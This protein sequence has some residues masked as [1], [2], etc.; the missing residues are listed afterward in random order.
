MSGAD[1]GFALG[2]V[3][4]V[5]MGAIMSGLQV[6]YFSL[7]PMKLQ[8]LQLDSGANPVD[9]ARAA[10]LIPM[11]SKH[12]WLLVTLLVVNAAAMET[13]PILLD[14]LVPSYIAIIMSVTLVLI[15]GEIIPQ[16][17]CTNRPLLIGSFF[18]PMIRVLMW[19]TCPVSWPMARLLDFILGD[20]GTHF[21]LKKTELNA[22]V[23]LHSEGQGGHL[24][25]DEVNIM[26]GALAF[27]E[28]P[29]YEIMTP[30]AK[31]FMVD[32]SRTLDFTL[33]NEIFKSGY[34]R[35]PVYDVSLPSTD[36]IV[37]LLIVK[38]LILLDPE[39]ETPVSTILEFYPHPLEKVFYDSGCKELLTV[40]KSGRAHMAVVH[41]I[42]N[43]G[44]GDPF[45]V[46]MGLVT[47]EDVIESILQMEIED[48]SDMMTVPGAGGDKDDDGAG[49]LLTS[50]TSTGREMIADRYRRRNLPQSLTPN[51][52]V[53]VLHF[54]TENVDVFMAGAR[55]ISEDGLR[56]LIRQA[57]V[58]DVKVKHSHSS[59]YILS[60]PPSPHPP[61]SPKGGAITGPSST[62]PP[63]LASV[64][65]A[66]GGYS[67]YRRGEASEYFTLVIDGSAK[68]R[69]GVDEFVVDVGNWAVLGAQALKGLHHSHVVKGMKHRKGAGSGGEVVLP[70]FVPDFS[71]VL[72]SPSRVL[73]V[74][75]KAYLMMLRKEAG[76]EV[77][78]VKEVTD[79]RRERMAGGV[80]HA[81]LLASGGKR[82]GYLAPALA[83]LSP[84]AS[85][86]SVPPAATAEAAASAAPDRAPEPATAATAQAEDEREEE[87]SSLLALLKRG[88]QARASVSPR[89]GGAK[90]RDALHVDIYEPVPAEDVEYPRDDSE[91]KAKDERSRLT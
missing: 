88:S 64:D 11:L 80:A 35:I 65:L 91:E 89:S 78:E 30:L 34:S 26:K 49:G 1:A 66:F 61:S 8:L 59:T 48:E 77:E 14:N 7:D 76:L 33:L 31:C 47:L 40:M 57:K 4:C 86:A 16:A 17:L 2:S 84:P 39:E 9:Q 5:C 54:L 15:C 70:P 32:R 23:D 36:N 28:R 6:G 38:D 56:T 44:S 18:A 27:S 74:S 24:K 69:A 72:T 60:S 46:N 81:N 58:M 43:Q 29:V 37:G 22:L 19:V 87:P 75:R 73:R 45:R 71:A 79:V 68:I 51:E 12:H 55:R 3:A 21:L 63:S 42:N 53:A 62:H 20:D 50:T 82:D 41:D 83:P 85:A 90:E 13:L 52:E 25:P 67:L 10:G